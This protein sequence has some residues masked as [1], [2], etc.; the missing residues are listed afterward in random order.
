MA[1]D[2]EAVVTAPVGRSEEESPSAAVKRLPKGLVLGKDGK[3]YVPA[4]TAP[5]PAP[6]CYSLPSPQNPV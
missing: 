2:G 3:P 1:E 6:C 5:A 4:A